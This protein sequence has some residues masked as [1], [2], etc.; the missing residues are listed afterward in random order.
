VTEK[1]VPTFGTTI[2]IARAHHP[3]YLSRKVGNLRVPMDRWRPFVTADAQIGPLRCGPSAD[4]GFAQLVR[5]GLRTSDPRQPC[6]DM[7]VA[8]V[9]AR[10]V[11]DVSCA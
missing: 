11:D 1:L 8:T 10:A 2:R 9:E 6:G 5:L 7:P 4:R 3:S